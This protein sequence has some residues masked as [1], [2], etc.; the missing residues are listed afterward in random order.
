MKSNEPIA[1]VSE[2]GRV[3]SLRAHLEG[4]AEKA[5]AFARQFASSDWARNA[6][7]LHD[8]GKERGDYVS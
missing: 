1:H 3:H 2:D 7:L 4:T 6:G 5:A 8:L